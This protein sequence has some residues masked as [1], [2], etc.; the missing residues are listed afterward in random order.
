[1]DGDA[2][3]FGVGSTEQDVADP[4]RFNFEIAWEVAHKGMYSNALVGLCTGKLV[5]VDS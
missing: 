2:N 1:M 3:D 4:F 5:I